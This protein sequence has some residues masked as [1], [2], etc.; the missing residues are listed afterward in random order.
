MDQ[1]SIQEQCCLARTSLHLSHPTCII[2]NFPAGSSA[3]TKPMALMA[4]GPLTKQSQ[5]C[6]AVLFWIHVGHL[7]S[8]VLAIGK[9]KKWWVPLR[10]HLQLYQYTEYRK[11]WCFRVW[12]NQIVRIQTPKCLKTQSLISKRTELFPSQKPELKTANIKRWMGKAMWQKTFEK[13]HTSLKSFAAHISWW[14]W[15]LD[16]MVKSF[17]EHLPPTSPAAASTR[18]WAPAFPNRWTLIAKPPLHRNTWALQPAVPRHLT[19]AKS[20]IHKLWL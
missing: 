8:I 7:A 17:I 20:R 15:P 19:R 10:Q 2:A 3:F 5:K 4:H 9:P 14:F 6:L 12:Q 1:V 11:R 18:N 13:L 16:W